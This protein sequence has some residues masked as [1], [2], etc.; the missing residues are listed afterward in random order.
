M[1]SIIEKYNRPIV[2]S[3]VTFL[4]MINAI[5]LMEYGIELS[6]G[7]FFSFSLALLV[8]LVISS[9][10]LRK[11]DNSIKERI[12]KKEKLVIAIFVEIL[13]VIGAFESYELAP[14]FSVIFLEIFIIL[15]LT[16]YFYLF[17]KPNQKKQQGISD[18]LNIPPWAYLLFFL[19]NGLLIVTLEDRFA[20]K[21]H[22]GI[23]MLSYFSAFVVFLISWVF[24]QIKTVIS[25][26][27]EQKRTELRHLQSQVNPHFFFNMLNNLYGWVEK[28]SKKA[29][30]MILGLS[31]LMRYSIYDGQ[32]EFVSLEQE[33]A[34]LKNYINLHKSRYQKKIEISF[35]INKGPNDIKI[36]PLLLIILLEN[37][38][39]H[40]IE[41]LRSNGYVH[42]NLRVNKTNFEFEIENNFDPEVERKDQGIGLQ[43][44]RRRL[45]LAYPNKHEFTSS[46]VN[47]IFKTKLTLDLS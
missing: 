37:A 19:G 28:D 5:V 44:L 29:Q 41:K 7:L 15:L 6:G 26:K 31:D 38:F 43:N 24:Q 17:Q 18:Q 14:I 16:I 30:E 13:L 3:L 1:I 34:Y 32:L 46:K 33:I 39:K 42:I 36:K 23:A 22:F 40:G 8:Y 21:D 27:N 35:N 12:Y 10:F 20:D 2:M 25:L 9:I 4:L 47:D 11:K 45:E